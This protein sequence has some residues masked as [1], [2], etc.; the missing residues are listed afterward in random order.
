MRAT[1]ALPT[2]AAWRNRLYQ[3]IFEADT[4]AGKAFDQHAARSDVCRE[5][6]PLFLG[7]AD[8]FRKIVFAKNKTHK[9]QHPGFLSLPERGLCQR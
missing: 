2:R 6:P 3:I 7:R 4:P 5:V 1:P 9:N 8:L